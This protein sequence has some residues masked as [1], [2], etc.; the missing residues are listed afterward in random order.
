MK[1][2]ILCAFCSISS[3]LL[4]SGTTPSSPSRRACLRPVL[5][6]QRLHIHCSHG[7]PTLHP[8]AT[9]GDRLL[10]HPYT[11]LP[12]LPRHPQIQVLWGKKIRTSR[13]H[14]ASPPRFV[15]CSPG[16]R[17]VPAHAPVEAAVRIPFRRRQPS[18]SVAVADSASPRCHLFRPSARPQTTPPAPRCESAKG[19]ERGSPGRGNLSPIPSAAGPGRELLGAAALFPSHAFT[20][21]EGIWDCDGQRLEM[22]LEHPRDY[23]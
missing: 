20:H 12:I 9:G 22:A 6:L 7:N 3:G 13:R 21:R 19:K 1:N 17:R 8:P 16:R 5:A 18:S 14:S 23:G 4:G 15:R 11:G 10:E 2:E